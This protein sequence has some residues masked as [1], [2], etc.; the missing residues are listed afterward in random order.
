MFKRVFLI[1]VISI[2]C[3]LGVAQ[4]S[5]LRVIPT[6]KQWVRNGWQRHPRQEVRYDSAGRHLRFPQNRDEYY[7][8]TESGSVTIEGN[9]HW[10]MATLAQLTDAQ[11]RLPDVEIHDWAEYPFRGF[12]HDVGRNFQSLGLL[13]ETLDLMAFYKINRFHWHLTD[14]PAWRIECRCFP[15]LNDPQFQRPGR[16]CGKF[17][18]YDEIRELIAYARERGIMVVPEIDMPGHSAYFTAAFGF[19]MDSEEGMAVIERLIDEFCAEIPDTLCPYL[20]IGSDEV[21]VADPEGFMTFTERMARKHHRQPVAWDPGLPSAPSTIRQVWNT[22]AVS[23][24]QAASKGGRFI[25]SFM[26]Y[27]NYYDPIYF[28][29][30]LFLHKAC[31]QDTPDTTTALGGIL[32]LWNDVRVDEKE[33]IALHNGMVN[34]MMAY[35][36]RFWNGGSGTWEQLAGFE[37]TMAFHR[38][39]LLADHDIRWVANAQTVWDIRINSATI[40]TARGGAL[41]LDALCTGHNLSRDTAMAEA[42]TLLFAARDTVIRAWV[43]FETPARSNRISSGIG[44][45]GEWENRGRLWVNGKEILPPGP[46]QEPGRY[47]YRF[48]TWGK[49]QEEEPF[50]DEQLYWMREPAYIPL[51]AGWNTVKMLVPK[52]F[53][54]QRWGFAF[55]PLTVGED[56]RVRETLISDH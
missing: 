47:A 10:A 24:A 43:G 37:K 1:A 42:T 8:R 26:G 53:K 51:R 16:D 40:L 22:A 18:T 49:P 3:L 29:N 36:E 9:R 28:T 17:Y 6:P 35:A 20:H 4:E 30:K 23:N 52:Q 14:Y 38:D 34:G 54:G 33:N 11:G 50:T 46:W 7:L 45:Q 12:M 55:L 48:H 27:L 31:N 21:H 15:Q 19:A 13:K 39:S 41:D 2:A 25:D 5:A 56:G 32:C 44:Q